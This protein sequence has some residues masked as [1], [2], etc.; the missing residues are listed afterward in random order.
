MPESLINMP[1]LD[2]RSVHG[3]SLLLAQTGVAANQ[4]M[5]GKCMLV[6]QL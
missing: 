4:M 2:R 6:E 1:A 5:S 3:V